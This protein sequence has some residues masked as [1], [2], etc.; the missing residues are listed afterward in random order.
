MP[1]AT[2]AAEQAVWQPGPGWLFCPADRPDRYLKA[3]AA[4][5]V[6]ILDLEDAVAP[7]KKTQARDAIRG[8]I[9]DGSFDRSRTV[10]R[11]NGADSDERA[12]DVSLIAELDLPRVMPAKAEDAADLAALPGELVALVETARGV[13]Q[14]SALAK[15]P[16]VVAMMWGADDLIASMGGTGSRHADGR[17]RDVVRY[18]RAQ[19]LIAAKAS[20][21][22]ALDGVH[23]DI[24]D[25]DGLTAECADAV[26]SGFDA[27]VAIHPSQVPVIR[28]TYAPA[29]E[30]IDWARRL[31]A[32]VGDERGVT[33]FEGRMVD[34][35]IYR[36][37]ERVLR[38]AE[39]TQ[40]APAR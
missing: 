1:E 38:L 22:L 14:A 26:A 18:A 17:Y 3:L 10:V 39:L 27:T 31:L 32:H 13:D 37:A 15:V 7:E 20:G 21:L 23:M 16:G 4:A 6:V 36:Q 35:P 9:D 12:A 25:T 5:D 33:T 34:G 8:L 28:S 19:V 30:R 40:E 11:I 24:P 29:P 2:S